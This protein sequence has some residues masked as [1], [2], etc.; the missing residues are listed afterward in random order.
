MVERRLV[1]VSRM[2]RSVVFDIE[3]RLK[4]E[5]LILAT[6]RCRPAS[7]VSSFIL[8]VSAW[9]NTVALIAESMKGTEAAQR[10][11]SDRRQALVAFIS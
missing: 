7:E 10:A 6:L 3:L 2:T 1:P 8:L 9:E 5:A 11:W 4:M